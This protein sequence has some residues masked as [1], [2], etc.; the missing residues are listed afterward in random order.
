VTAGGELPYADPQSALR[1][2]KHEQQATLMAVR[3]VRRWLKRVLA[4]TLVIGCLAGLAAWRY[5][6]WREKFA[7]AL[8]PPGAP[9]SQFVVAYLRALDAY[10]KVTAEALSA[11]AERATT[12]SWLHS[13]ASITGIRIASVH[14]YAGGE[15]Y[16]VCMNFRYSSHW[17]LEDPSFPD[18]SEY[19]C[20]YL[21][22]RY[23]R[24]LIADDGLP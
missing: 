24:W 2:Q 14:H 12:A 5:W 17:W 6:P 9:P 20:Y 19:W 16:E 23:D 3:P 18:G 15:P 7:V 22:H 1:G 21:V 11:P 13:T 8:P 10:D 4:I